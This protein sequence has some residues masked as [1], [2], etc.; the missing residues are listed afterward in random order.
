MNKIKTKINKTQQDTLNKG[1]ILYIS[2]DASFTSDF[3]D[4]INGLSIY[5]DKKSAEE[6][7]EQDERGSVM[8]ELT[9]K[10]IYVPVQK[11]SL[12]VKEVETY[13]YKSL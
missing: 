8:F 9:V 1:D 12:P 10:K 13:K 4:F 5:K 3:E 6:N 2:G 11:I 7:I